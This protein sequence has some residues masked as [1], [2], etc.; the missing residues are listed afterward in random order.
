[1]ATT[2]KIHAEDIVRV[3]RGLNE[4][5]QKQLDSLDEKLKQGGSEKITEE[6]L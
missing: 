3:L 2:R 1:M 5:R 6:L 4:T